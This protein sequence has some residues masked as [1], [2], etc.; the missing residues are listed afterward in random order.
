MNRLSRVIACLLATTGPAFATPLGS[1][2]TYQGNLNFNGAP[3]NGSFDVSFSLF[4]VS[5]N[6]SPVDTIEQ[7]DVV[8][9]GGLISTTLDFT[10][11]PFDGQA[12]WI[13]VSV[14]PSGTGT[15]TTLTPR[16]PLSATPYALFA[17][18]GNP[19]PQGPPGAT[20]ATGPLGPTGAPGSVGATGPTGA[21]GMVALPFAQ[22]ISSVSPGLAITNSGD[23]LNGT[24]S[25]TYNSGVY[26]KNTSGKG[27]FGASTSGLGVLGESTSASGVEGVSQT[28]S[29]V[30]GSTS[31]GTTNQG[32]AGVW[33]DSGS[34]YGVWGTSYRNDGVHGTSTSGS[35][36]AG[37]SDSG[38]GM[39]TDGPTQQS[40][41]QGGWAK[42]MLYVTINEFD[43][44]FQLSIP[45]CFNSQLP[46]SRASVPP[47]G[48]SVSLYGGG[49]YIVD[50]GFEVDDRFVQLTE[51]GN[52]YASLNSVAAIPHNANQ[53]AITTYGISGSPGAGGLVYRS[54]DAFFHVAVF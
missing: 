39:A 32:A 41:S 17:L 34:Y 15:F 11:V 37:H 16:E 19:G 10:D 7:D 13:E 25:G 18:H 8:V 20:G 38:Y 12:L 48:F 5:S 54:E 9:V 46:A 4:T 31:G 43:G 2:F 53:L 6:G 29:G 42:A 33:G 35:G 51:E 14:R 21:A 3:A 45:R 26:G 1:A 30:F 47:C 27:V 22:T 52:G 50:F 24:S 40:R 49:I 28:G 23:G 44:N 36:V